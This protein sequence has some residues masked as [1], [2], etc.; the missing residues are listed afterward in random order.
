[1]ANRERVL[2][3]FDMP[4]IEWLWSD[5]SSSDREQSSTDVAIFI[6]N[7]TEQALGD[8]VAEHIA[9]LESK[10][11]KII[12]T[13]NTQPV[14][15]RS[16]EYEHFGFRDG[17]SQPIIQGT[18][19]FS[20]STLPHDIVSAGE[21]I[22]GYR[23]NQ[24]MVS[25][26]LTVDAASDNLHHLPVPAA[27]APSRFPNFGADAVACP[28]RDFGRNGTFL[29]IRQ[30]AQDVE[31][32]TRF[33]EKQSVHLNSNPN[34]QS[35]I[36]GPVTPEWIASKMMGRWHDG[37]PMIDRPSPPPTTPSTTERNPTERPSNDFTYGI[38]DPTG[39]K[40]P[41]GAHIR[42]TNPRDSLIP[43]DPTQLSITNR[44]RLLRRGRPYEYAPAEN[45]EKE[46]GLLFVALCADIERQFEFI[47]QTWVQSPRFHGLTNEP[48]PVVSSRTTESDRRFTIPLSSGSLTLQPM[49]DFVTLR[50][51][52]YFFLPSRSAL[53]FL[54]SRLD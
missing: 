54:A 47:Q 37:T 15:D 10:G 6:Y 36:G 28:V 14:A 25:P 22:L 45:A 33:T 27:S 11:G 7:E 39:Q 21:F 49:Q 24:G 20:K 52:G 17:I 23:N 32:F 30:L 41:L 46:K 42:R 8:S 35:I 34:L 53:H 19:R 48:D 18:Q 51:G 26:S 4:S 44:H 3:D 50:A 2:G 9:F 29:V 38:D 31:G 12:H 13:I 1:M 5:Q 40:C 16:I 43:E